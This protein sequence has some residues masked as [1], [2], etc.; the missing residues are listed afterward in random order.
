MIGEFETD[1]PTPPNLKHH[2]QLS[3]TEMTFKEEVMTIVCVFEDIGNPFQEDSGELL[4][5]DTREIMNDDVIE[6]TRN[7]VKMGEQQYA[8]ILF[9]R[10]RFVKKSKPINDPIH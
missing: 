1:D 8:I 3:S 9:I 4:T 6:T 7:I 5:L 2:E 10:E